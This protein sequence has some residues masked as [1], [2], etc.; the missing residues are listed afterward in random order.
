MDLNLLS[1]IPG[2][3]AAPTPPASDI[4]PLSLDA[5]PSVQTVARTLDQQGPMTS[6]DLRGFTGLPRRTIHNALRQLRERNLLRE[7]ASLR[8]MRQT[9]YWLLG[10]KPNT[11]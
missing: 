7:R 3:S 9:Y 10:T 6:A 2:R 5:P 8:D 4:V 1:S 11:S